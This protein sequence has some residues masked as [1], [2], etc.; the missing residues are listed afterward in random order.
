MGV[1]VGVSLPPLLFSIYDI[2]C[3]I[4]TIHGL[5]LFKNIIIQNKTLGL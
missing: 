5:L 3:F 2:Y 1:C 4:M